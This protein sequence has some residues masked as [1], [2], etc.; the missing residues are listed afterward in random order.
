MTK[1]ERKMAVVTYTVTVSGGKATLSPTIDQVVF[2]TRDYIIFEQAAGTSAEILVQLTGAGRVVVTAADIGHTLK[3]QPPTIN[4][5]GNVVV[6]F[7]IEGG[8]PGDTGNY[9][10]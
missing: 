2:T 3:L 8:N 1:G 9:P 6:A 5:D 4:T 10:P 7:D